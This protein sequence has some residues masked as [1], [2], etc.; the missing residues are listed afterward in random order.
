MI[1]ED[2]L[3]QTNK[4][5]FTVVNPTSKLFKVLKEYQFCV[6]KES[7]I[8][9]LLCSITLYSYDSVQKV[10]NFLPLQCPLNGR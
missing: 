10:A 8:K 4:Q 1:I 9:T 6:T 7:N 2:P 3:R 5:K